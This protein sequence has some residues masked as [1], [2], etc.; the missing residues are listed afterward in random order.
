MVE[1]PRFH[2]T[3]EVVGFPARIVSLRQLPNRLEDA[4]LFDSEVMS[5]SE[6]GHLVSSFLLYPLPL[7]K[8]RG[9]PVKVPSN[10]P[11]DRGSPDGDFPNSLILPS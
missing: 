9:D 8:E 10:V 1:R 6:V 11:D 7:Q 5:V 2:P 4:E 3:T